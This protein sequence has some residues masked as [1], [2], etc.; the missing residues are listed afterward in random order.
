M[1]ILTR[2]KDQKL[3]INDNIEI[4]VVDIAGDQVKLGIVAPRDVKIYR[5]EV[6]EN[7]KQENIEAA[8]VSKDLPKLDF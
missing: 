1:L 6:Y 5:S 4:C 3:I 8:K 7:I 2:K